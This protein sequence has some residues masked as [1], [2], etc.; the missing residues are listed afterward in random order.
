MPNPQPRRRQGRFDLAE[1]ARLSG[2]PARTIRYYIAQEL[3]PPPLGR[4]PGKHYDAAHLARLLAVRGLRQRGNDLAS[5]RRAFAS[6]YAHAALMRGEQPPHTPAIER[7]S[8]EADMNVNLLSWLPPGALGSGDEAERLLADVMR[9]FATAR[10][11]AEQEDDAADAAPAQVS[12]SSWARLTLAPGLELHVSGEHS[13]PAT[14]EL[15][16]IAAACRRAFGV[17]E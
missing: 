12:L 1:L 2:V 14:R 6:H 16:E 3:V 15:D 9:A 8:R 7:A 13:L 4:G 10:L 5:L 11:A 17:D